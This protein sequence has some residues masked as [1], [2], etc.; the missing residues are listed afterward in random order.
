MTKITKNDA[1]SLLKETG[2]WVVGCLLYS[3]GVNVFVLPNHLAQTGMTGASV[4]IHRLTDW[5]V[6]TVGLVLNIPLLVLMW[7]F[8][9][10]KSFAKTVWATVLL[11]LCLDAVAFVVSKYGIEYTNDKI[12]AS[13]ITGVLEG[14]GLGLIMTTGATSGGTDIIGKLV[15][16]RWSHITVGTIVM[17]SDAT[18]VLIYMIVFKTIDSG[19]YALIVAFVSSRCMDSLLYG[20]GNGKC[21]MIFTDKADEVS[22]AMISNSPRGVSILPAKGAYSGEDRN[23]LIC[24]ARK[25]EIRRLIKIVKSVDSKVFIIVSEANEILGNGF[26]TDF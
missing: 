21:I 3:I 8:L 18:I 9:G 5:P 6:G 20:M 25:H 13:L 16:K 10:R 2:I 15:N 12:L 24:V 14:S 23:M 7:L 26:N 11:S 19:L 22:K 17:L 1:V 4:I